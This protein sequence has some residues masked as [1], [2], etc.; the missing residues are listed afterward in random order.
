MPRVSAIIP[1][2]NH[3]RFVDGAVQSALS[4]TFHDLEAIVIN[5]GSTDPY[6]VAV[7]SHYYSRSRTRVLHTQNQGL[8]AARN[9]AIRHSSGEYLLILDAD[10]RFRPTFVEKAAAIL[11]AKPEVGMVAAWAQTYGDFKYEIH[12]PGGGAVDC[13]LKSGCCACVLLRRK[14]WESVG[15]YDED[16]RMWEDWDF[17]MMATR[18]GW[19]VE[20]IPEI[21]FDCCKMKGSMSDQGN[22]DLAA[23]KSRVV[24]KHMDFFR[25]HVVEAI[26]QH[27]TEIERMERLIE[28]IYA[29]PR[30]KIGG[31][32]TVPFS[33]LRGAIHKLRAREHTRP[34]SESTTERRVIT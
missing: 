28:R 26:W 33:R 19:A 15:G 27:N 29:S 17:Y 8:S 2:Y 9:H 23:T 12:Y 30:Y 16:I 1:C 24:E 3:G 10:D 5:D 31:L 11:D 25:E 7:L 22:R 20:I 6:T 34:E 4:Q 32:F 14:C 21:L 13:L 18:N